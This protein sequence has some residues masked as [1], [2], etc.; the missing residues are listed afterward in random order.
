MASTG[1]SLAA[2]AESAGTSCWRPLH[3]QERQIVTAGALGMTRTFR[4]ALL[5]CNL[6]GADT[7]LWLAGTRP[8]QPEHELAR[9]PTACA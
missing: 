7:A 9:Q 8:A 6:P 2:P 5:R 4:L 1:W 3:E